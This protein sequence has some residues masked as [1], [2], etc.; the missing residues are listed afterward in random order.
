M[1]SPAIGPCHRPRRSSRAIATRLRA[2]LA[3]NEIRV[4]FQP[5]VSLAS[6][7]MIG[8]E[9]LARW[10]D[11]ELGV[12]PPEIFIPVAEAC[13]CILE[14]TL[15]VLGRALRVVSSLRLINPSATV[16]V[17]V[18]P[19]LLHD[20]SFADEVGRLLVETG[21]GPETL[22]AEITET[23]V[24]TRDAVVS[25]T[26]RRLR[27]LGV[28]CSIDDFGTGHASLLALL[29]MPFS[30]LKID[31][32]FVMSCDADLEAWKIVQ[33][34]L[35]L[36]RELRLD[37]VAEGIETD[38]VARKLRD[39]GCEVGQGFRFGAAMPGSKL[40]SGAL[41]GGAGMREWGNEARQAR[42]P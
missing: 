13:G 24:L 39:G 3:L 21:M 1:S 6:G 31:R 11:R 17:N 33:A 14:L 2:A 9:A 35:R 23:A 40:L 36:A 38:R 20:P 4:A 15:F 8:V 22:V 34:T 27:D 41:R 18:S 28:G 16:A 37:V 25:Q 19:V 12:V 29:R 32:A 10:T 5:K 30:E 26:L 42:C 7:D